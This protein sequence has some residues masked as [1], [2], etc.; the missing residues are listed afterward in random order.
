MP[1][2]AERVTTILA[3]E[4]LVVGCLSEVQSAACTLDRHGF[5]GKPDWSELR[6]PTAP[7]FQIKPSLFHTLILERLRLPL[8]VTEAHCECAR[9]DRCGKH[10]AACGRSGRLRSRAT[11]TETRA[12]YDV[13]P[14]CE[15]LTSPSQLPMKG[16]LKFLLLGRRPAHSGFIWR[17]HQTLPPSTVQP[18]SEHGVRDK[19]TKYWELLHENRCQLD[20]RAPSVP[21]TAT[22]R[23]TARQFRCP[24]QSGGSPSLARSAFLAWHRRWSRMISISCGRAF[25][26]SLVS[27]IAESLQ[28]IDGGIPHFAD[29][30]GE[31]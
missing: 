15:R 21:Q 30:F 7:E 8:Q 28:G 16:K 31:M 18:F 5:V 9:L 10:R 6:C 14:S 29:L 24:Q 20:W 12:R 26:S 23:S 2:V 3:R 1:A 25:A 27:F 19:E 13:T 22:R 11:A 17:S 4:D